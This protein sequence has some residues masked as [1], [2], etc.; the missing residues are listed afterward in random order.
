MN[1]SIGI[2]MKT[3]NIRTKDLE[4]LLKAFEY[5]I[6][7]NDR[8]CDVCKFCGM[9]YGNAELMLRRGEKLTHHTNCPYLVA[10]DIGTGL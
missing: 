8:S 2:Y 5:Y 1:L 7:E 6:E 10:L 3:I 9:E 4:I